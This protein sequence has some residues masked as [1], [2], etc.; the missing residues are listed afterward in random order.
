MLFSG[1]TDDFDE[2]DWYEYF[3]NMYKKIT[4]EDI[5][6]YMKSYAGSDKQI[7]DVKEAY[8]K[9]KGNIDLILQT[10]IGF[11]AENE[12]ELTDI[13]QRLIDEG[14]IEAYRK[15]TNRS[16]LDRKKRLEKSKKEAKEAKKLKEDLKRKGGIVARQF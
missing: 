8:I 2:K 1:L 10:V 14:E 7:A 16:E 12:S 4:E 3:R 15:F 6:N 5:D 11:D 13:I 9:H